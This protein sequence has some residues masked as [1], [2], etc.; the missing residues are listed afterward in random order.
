[1]ICVQPFKVSSKFRVPSSGYGVADSSLIKRAG[2][3]HRFH[4]AFT[5]KHHQKVADHGS[6][7]LLVE[8]DHLLAADLL[9]RHFDH[10]DCAFHDL[11]ARGD[12]RSRL[13]T[14]QHGTGDLRSVRKVADTRFDHLDT[15]FRKA[16]LDLMTQT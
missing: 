4:A 9:E 5:A 8:V 3:D 15:C 7:A 14:S 6:L 11:G 16:I 1:M 12:D 13:L 10:A 2:V